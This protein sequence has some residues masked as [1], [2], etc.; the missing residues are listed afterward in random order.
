MKLSI[1]IDISNYSDVFNLQ[2]MMDNIVTEVRLQYSSL[3]EGSGVSFSIHSSVNNECIGGWR[4]SNPFSVFEVYDNQCEDVVLVS[5]KEQ[6]E[7]YVQNFDY[8]NSF[9]DNRFEI[10]EAQ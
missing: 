2:K 9:V 3:D 8:S 1:E 4:L 10:R 5:S 6:C 7:E